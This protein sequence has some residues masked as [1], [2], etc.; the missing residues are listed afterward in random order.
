MNPLPEPEQRQA[1][2]RRLNDSG[3]GFAGIDGVWWRPAAEPFALPIA[4]AQEL[5]EIGGALF[6]FFDIVSALYQQ[7]AGAGL[8]RLLA[9]KAPS[10]VRHWLEAGRVESVRPDFQLCPTGDPRAP[11][12]L[13]VTELEICPSAHGFAQAMQLGYGLFP[14]LVD[15]FERYLA[16]RSL[17]FVGTHQW[18]EFIIEQL[19]FCRA[20]AEQ[21]A[22]GWVLYDRP[23]AQ[24]AAEIQQETR[25][26]LPLFG[27]SDRPL[28]WDIDLLGR[29]QRRGLLPYLWPDDEHWPVEVGE[30]VVFRFGYLDQFS[31]EHLAT[32]QRWQRHGATLLNPLT[33]FLDSKVLLAAFQLPEIRERLA[34][35]ALTI[36]ARCLPE[37]C[38]LTPEKLPELLANKDQWVLKF[39]GFDGGNQAWGGRSLLIGREHNLVEWSALLRQYLELPWPVVAQQAVPTARV[40]L[41]YLTAEGDLAV[42]DDGHARLRSFF[43]RGQSE[44]IDLLP[45]AQA[46]GSHVTFSGGTARVAEGINS[47]QAP[48]VYD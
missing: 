24:M 36:L 23:L 42:L 44:S 5:N 31:D 25:W 22:N 2:W 18:S 37:T 35:P 29:L 4:L 45:P 21:G 13:V 38:L 32:V 12:R 40:S 7:E 30:A 6:Y 19:A 47:V 26:Q 10:R 15:G 43:L 8:R 27:I 11:Y 16:G 1:I 33:F 9:E 14:D 17:L 34:G 20:L 41:P 3:I 46:C 48:V 39:A 28:N